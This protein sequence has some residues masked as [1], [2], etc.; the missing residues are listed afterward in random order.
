MGFLSPKPPPIAPLPPLPTR[1]DP[2]IAAA[3]EKA[4][5]AGGRGRGRKATILTSP[6]GATDTANLSR[7]AL[8]GEV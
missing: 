6:L 5:L 7:K 2:S 3:R 8:L 1:A 4:R